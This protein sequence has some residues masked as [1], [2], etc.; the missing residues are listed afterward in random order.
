VDREGQIDVLDLPPM[1]YLSPRLSPDGNRLAVQVNEEGR[2]S[3]WVYEMSGD[4]QIRALTPNG[5][6]I[7]PV[8]TAD[9]ERV[10]FASDREGQWG[11]YWQPADGSSV[12]QRLTTAEEGRQHWPES[13]SPDGSTLSFAVVDGEA[14]GLWLLSLAGGAFGTE[15]FYDAAGFH[16]NGSVFSPE[17]DWLAYYSNESNSDNQIYVQS[18]PPSG[19]QHQITLD[20]GVFPLWAADGDELIYRRPGTA[21]ID[22]TRLISVELTGDDT[23]TAGPERLLPISGF[24]VVGAYRDY[25]I[26][27]DGERFLMVFSEDYAA[28]AGAPR[29]QVNVVL[30][31]FEELA[32][33]VPVR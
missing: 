12:A 9:S 8:W 26:T 1:P 7:R 10:T 28:P 19:V 23:V 6:S 24:S 15:L 4:T 3:I 32:D 18:V 17:G 14:R 5:N 20:G 31:W 2:N 25:D 30:N 16:Q 29:R 11:I 21:A 27:P 33:R 22:G 13:W